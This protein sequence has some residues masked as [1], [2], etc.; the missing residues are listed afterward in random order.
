M[1]VDPTTAAGRSTHAGKEYYF[2]SASCMRKFDAN[3]EQY[4]GEGAKA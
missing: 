4:A 2:C 3:P 1:N